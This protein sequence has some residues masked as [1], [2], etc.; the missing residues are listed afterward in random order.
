MERTQGL[1]ALLGGE[2]ILEVPATWPPRCE[3]AA[4]YAAEAVLEGHTCGYGQTSSPWRD[5]FE[6]AVAADRGYKFA[7]GTTSGTAALAGGI[8]A[9][10]SARGEAWCDGR[11]TLV[12]PAWTVIQHPYG[13]SHGVHDAL[14]RRPRLVAIDSRKDPTIDEVQLESWLDQNHERVLAVCPVTLGD[15]WCQ[16]DAIVGAARRYDLP[17]VHDGAQCGGGRYVGATPPDVG[18]ESDQWGKMMG[19]ASGEGGVILTNDRAIAKGARAWT[20]CGVSLGGTNDPTRGAPDV[21]YPLSGNQRLSGVLAAAALGCREEMIPR[22]T[23]VRAVRRAL[24]TRIVADDT[25]VFDTPPIQSHWDMGPTFAFWLRLTP[26]AKGE[27]GLTGSHWQQIF[28]AEGFAPP[29]T[30]YRFAIRTGYAH[31]QRIPGLRRWGTLVPG[32][33]PRADGMDDWLLCHSGLLLRPS[34]PDDFRATVARAVR[35]VVALQHHFGV[36]R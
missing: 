28:A 23:V 25:V 15:T 7:V 35:N 14:G 31:I 9:L 17:V 6:A 22:L 29:D 30:P 18:T 33:F 1:P 8:A 11:D 12:V 26:E 24:G 10:L 16:L 34:T 19:F 21:E 2:P 13:L 27:Y 36:R 32:S 20:D 3:T 5:R 4:T